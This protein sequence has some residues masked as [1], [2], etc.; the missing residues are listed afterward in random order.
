MTKDQVKKMVE[1]LPEEDEYAVAVW[2]HK[3]V[4]MYADQNNIKV[5]EKKAREVIDY[6][7]KH[8]DAELGISWT[9]IDAW[10]NELEK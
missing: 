5:S 6:I 3:D 8:Q 9:T 10:L 2:S 4:L 1:D 7:D